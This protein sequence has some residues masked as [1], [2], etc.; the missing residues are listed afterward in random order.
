MEPKKALT[1]QEMLEKALRD[2]L[3][4]GVW[5]PKDKLPSESEMMRQYQVSRTLVRNV[6][7]NL[8]RD[9]LVKSK[10]GK[11]TFVSIPKIHAHAPYKEKIRSQL[12]QQGYLTQ[13]QFASL[14]KISATPKLAY[15]LNVDLDSTVYLHKHLRFVDQLPFSIS[16][17]FM[18]AGLFPDLELQDMEGIPL[19]QVFEEVYGYTV[20][21]TNETLEIIFAS[22]DIA[23]KL[24]IAAGFPLLEL[25]Q[26]NYSSDNVPFELNRILFRG[27]RIRL[28]FD[29]NR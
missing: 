2:N 19:S 6:L 13:T 8:A 29:Y 26:V 21:S 18:P 22:A 1:K 10:Q 16:E 11:G 27:D 24:D 3:K 5:N 28:H 20:F 17:S 14:E 9:G 15:L 7:T 4:N 25:E 23:K 12:E